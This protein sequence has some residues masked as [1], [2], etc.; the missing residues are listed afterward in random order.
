MSAQELVGT[1]RDV[2]W[3][4]AGHIRSGP[5]HWHVAFKAAGMT[6]WIFPYGDFTWTL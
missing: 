5:C 4:A 3:G 2:T 6:S 1:A